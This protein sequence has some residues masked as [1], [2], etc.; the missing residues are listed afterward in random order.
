MGILKALH[1]DTQGLATLE[2]SKIFVCSKCVSDK[3][4]KRGIRKKGENVS[5]N[6]CKSTSKKLKSVSFNTFVQIIYDGVLSEFPD[7]SDTLFYDSGDGGYQGATCDAR[8]LSDFI[9]KEAGISDVCLLE[10]VVN[11]LSDKQFCRQPVELHEIFSSRWDEFCELV[12]H[13]CRYTFFNMDLRSQSDS[14]WFY[15]SESKKI[16]TKLASIIAKCD[17]FVRKINVDAQIFRVRFFETL[18]EAESK[19][20]ASSLG[21]TPKELAASNRMSPAGIPFFYGALDEKTAL[22]ETQ[23]KNGEKYAAI[24]VFRTLSELFVLDLSQFPVEPSL[25]D[26]NKKELR[27]SI[28]FLKRFSQE[29]SKPICRDGGEH[30]DYVPTQIMAEYFRYIYKWK[31]KWNLDGIFYPSSKSETGV[32]CAFFIQND[33]CVESNESSSENSRLILSETSVKSI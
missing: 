4:L 2:G 12:K 28:R 18:G 10:A 26:K 16:L 19:K 7:P 30:I 15:D 1:F 17:G 8:D 31:R 9:K 14:Y 21:T 6:Y 20:S 13:R 24:G 23:R 11:A 3:A 25:F 5:C 29:I 22:Q 27:Q 33:Q 32:C